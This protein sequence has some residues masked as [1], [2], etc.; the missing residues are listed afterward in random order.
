M[1]LMNSTEIFMNSNKKIKQQ[2]LLANT[3]PIIFIILVGSAFV[4]LISK[5][6]VL[7]LSAD[8][9]FEIFV[10]SA[11]FVFIELCFFFFCIRPLINKL[12]EISLYLHKTANSDFLTKL[13]NR[14]AL[15]DDYNE[16]KS[17]KGSVFTSLVLLD[18]DNFK[19]VND[20]FGHKS[21]DD[22]LIHLAQI[23]RLY[24]DNCYRIGGEEFV[25]LYRE[26]SIEQTENIINALRKKIAANPCISL[27][28][29]IEYTCTF[30]L[31]NVNMNET[32]ESNLSK[33]DLALYTGKR[34]AEMLQ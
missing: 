5:V 9:Y 14:S 28:D 20:T 32:L 6:I 31:T 11:S 29:T 19:R 33:A 13:N 16:I 24:C 2:F 17:K 30:G 15:A 22:V 26:H 1:I 23:L 34:K 3:I 7:N 27:N 4:Y 8:P 10:L 21:G 18:I 25:L 12:K